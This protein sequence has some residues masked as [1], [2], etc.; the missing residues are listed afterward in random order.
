MLDHAVQ[1]YNPWRREMN[2]ASA[3]LASAFYVEAFSALQYEWEP[4]QITKV[5]LSWRERDRIECYWPMLELLGQSIRKE[6][7]HREGA[8][9]IYTGI[10]LRVWWTPSCMCVRWYSMSLGKEQ[11]LSKDKLLWYC[12]GNDQNLSRAGKPFISYDL[13]WRNLVEQH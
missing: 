12:D 11:L 3:M 8:P 13:E 2:E 4:H 10:P 6:E 5:L 7:L 9:K 1:F